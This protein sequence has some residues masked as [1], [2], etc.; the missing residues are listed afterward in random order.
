MDQHLCISCLPSTVDVAEQL[1]AALREASDF[2]YVSLSLT[3]SIRTWPEEQRLRA[4]YDRIA[5]STHLVAVI[6][7]NWQVEAVGLG[8]VDRLT[9]DMLLAALTGIPIVPVLTG[10]ADIP[11]EH[12]LP[13]RIRGL[14]GLPRLSIRGHRMDATEL[15]RLHTHLT[16]PA[17]LLECQQPDRG[18]VREVA[19]RDAIKR[20]DDLGFQAAVAISAA[21][22]ASDGD[23]VRLVGADAELHDVFEASLVHVRTMLQQWVDQEACSFWPPA[24][25][26]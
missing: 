16:G 24:K 17:S 14:A 22:L 25:L 2:Q 5:G 15:E 26:A 4:D 23:D 6:G 20:A 19:V 11:P 21:K 3:D 9:T 12:L 1:A 7:A 13:R 10:G 18:A 8:N